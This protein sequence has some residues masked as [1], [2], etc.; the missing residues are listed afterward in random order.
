MFDFFGIIE[1]LKRYRYNG[2]TRIRKV[3]YLLKR[4]GALEITIT[5]D[6]QPRMYVGTSFTVDAKSGIRVEVLVAIDADRHRQA[7]SSQG[8]IKDLA[9]L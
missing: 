8:E 1:I 9:F 6:A 5:V 2:K 4:H 3:V 7:N